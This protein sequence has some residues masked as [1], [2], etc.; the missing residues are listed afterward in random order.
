MSGHRTLL[1]APVQPHFTLG[2][3]V[4]GGHL[5]PPA[6]LTDMCWAL[7][8]QS[9]SAVAAGL[10]SHLEFLHGIAL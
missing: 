4:W 10:G 1:W 5:W 8:G 6:P 2:G 3:L 7:V 9:L